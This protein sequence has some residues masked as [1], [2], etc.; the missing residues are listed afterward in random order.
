MWQAR[1]GFILVLVG[2][3]LLVAAVTDLAR[4]I[5]V[6]SLGVILLVIYVATRGYGFLVAGAIL[7]GLGIGIVTASA[8]VPGEWP[9]L[10]LGLGFLAIPLVD[11]LTAPPR[12]AW[13]WPLLP[14][15]ALTVIGLIGLHPRYALPLALIAVGTV[16][17]L[18]RDPRRRVP[19]GPRQAPPHEDPAT[20][21]DLPRDTRP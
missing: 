1:L 18:K 14:G 20:D 11:R 4:E 2:A 17:L 21:Q 12:R 3:I 7:T 8:S 16:L 15:G 19:V 6:V 9:L 5:V 13:W 10:G